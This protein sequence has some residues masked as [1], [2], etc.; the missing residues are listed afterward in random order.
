MKKKKKG[1]KGE[2]GYQSKEI[3]ENFWQV[4]GE[5]NRNDQRSKMQEA[6]A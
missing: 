2:K 4:A 6:L 5:W 1:M 3:S